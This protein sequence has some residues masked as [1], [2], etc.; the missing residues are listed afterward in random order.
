MG[1]QKSASPESIPDVNV[2]TSNFV[3]IGFSEPSQQDASH[4]LKGKKRRS[5]EWNFGAS[6][7]GWEFNFPFGHS[8]ECCTW[9]VS[10]AERVWPFHQE[11]K[12]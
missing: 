8:M 9:N 4:A 6:L 5:C 12:T 3:T 1:V 2:Q 11:L 10:G 7:G